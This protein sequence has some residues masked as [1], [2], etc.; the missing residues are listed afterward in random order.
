M[1]DTAK[2]QGKRA[3]F[4]FKVPPSRR[5]AEEFPP[6]AA[7]GAAA[8]LR[9]TREPASEAP[10]IG[11]ATLAAPDRQAIPAPQRARFLAAAWARGTLQAPPRAARRRGRHGGGA[12]KPPGLPGFPAGRRPQPAQN[13][14]L[15]RFRTF[16]RHDR[17]DSAHPTAGGLLR[18]CSGLARPLPDGSRCRAARLVGRTTFPS[19]RHGRGSLLCVVWFACE[20]WT[21]CVSHFPCP[22]PPIP[23]TSPLVPLVM[24][25]DV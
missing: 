8:A 6:R 18:P 4:P 10:M 21:F 24:V 3:V 17:P 22:P 2:A 20:G 12:Q 25:G 1:Q 14:P 16:Q 23:P 15:A 19:L 13:P 9:A 7:K 5:A 11:G